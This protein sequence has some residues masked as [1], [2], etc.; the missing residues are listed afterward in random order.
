MA[1]QAL[2]RKWRS[3]TFGELVGQEPVVQT[4]RNAIR[5]GRIGHAYLFT[6]PRGV[7]KTTM[8]RLLAKAVNCLAPLEE[9][10]CDRCS[11]CRAI[12]EG[13]A[14]DVIE[15]DAA[16]HTGVDDARELIEKVQFRPTSARFKVYIIDEVHML[17]TAAFNAL[18][19]TLEEPPAHVLFILATTEFHKVPATITSRCQRF[20]FSRHSLSDITGHLNYVAHAE[21]IELEAGV[22]EQIARAATGAMRDALSILDQLM[23]GTDTVI[24]L[25]QVQG[26]LGTAPVSEVSSVV[27]A[28]VDGNIQA[29]LATIEQVAEGGADLRQFTRDLV[30]YLRSLMLVAATGKVDALD[31]PDEM[32][33]AIQDQATR[34]AVGPVVQ[35]LKL[36]ANLDQQLKNSPYGQLPLEM[37]VVEALTAPAMPIA[38]RVGL[39]SHNAPTRAT[40]T[41]NGQPRPQ[42]TVPPVKAN[43]SQA[44]SPA[45]LVAA[46]SPAPHKTQDE[47]VEQLLPPVTSSATPVQQVG[48]TEETPVVVPERVIEIEDNAAFL[49]EE[50]IALWEQFLLDIQAENRFIRAALPGVKPINVDGHVL[51]MLAGKGVWQKKKL[52]EEKSRRLLERILSKLLNQRVGVRF[53]IDQQEEMPDARKLIQHARSDSLIRKAINIFEAEI[54]GIDTP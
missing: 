50:V 18:L 34:T 36:F 38:A 37:A 20:A 7:G 40:S 1:G 19:K 4:L 29:G 46:V 49:L 22:A 3:Q 52:E 27:G 45:R 54:V 48:S 25:Q 35:W 26:L 47:Q 53:T 24:T 5:S 16:S 51:V 23:A 33:S 32:L 21:Q 42:D 39:P 10:P 14:L 41:T 6:G 12:A 30:D 13:R 9:R 31:L 8:A 2:Y 17:S 44:A 11:E 43:M 15:M 28:L